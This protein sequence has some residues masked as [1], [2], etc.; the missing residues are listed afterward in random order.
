MDAYAL[1]DALTDVRRRSGGC[2]ARSG[3]AWE[4]ICWPPC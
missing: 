4:C 3:G 1:F 2:T